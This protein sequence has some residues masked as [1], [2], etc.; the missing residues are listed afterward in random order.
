M[1]RI[2]QLLAVIGAI[3]IAVLGWNLIWPMIDWEGAITEGSFRELEIGQSKSDV[4]IL[5]MTNLKR[6]R[7]K[8][9]GYWCENGQ[10]VVLPE[11]NC[12][13]SIYDAS[14]WSLSYPGIHNEAIRVVFDGPYVERIEYHRD[15]LSP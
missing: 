10:L 3:M 14:E 2:T 11:P 6:S 1:R 5:T 4:I 7:L 12:P 13:T 15:I 9:V 8:L